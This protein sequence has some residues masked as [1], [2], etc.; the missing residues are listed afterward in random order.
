[1]FTSSQANGFLYFISTARIIG[2]SHHDNTMGASVSKRTTAEQVLPE[3]RSFR[4]LRRMDSREAACRLGKLRR[5]IC[6]SDVQ[7][8]RLLRQLGPLG[9]DT[10]RQLLRLEAQIRT[11]KLFL[12]RR[13]LCE[14]SCLYEIVG[15]LEDMCCSTKCLLAM[16]AACQEH[17]SKPSNKC[18]TQVGRLLL[19]LRDKEEKLQCLRQALKGGEKA[20]N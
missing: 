13:G 4:V 1:M 3:R 20:T 8:S 11:T 14:V 19:E 9:F 10:E 5:R 12:E 15:E 18:Y 17:R 7:I 16:L 6:F 2:L